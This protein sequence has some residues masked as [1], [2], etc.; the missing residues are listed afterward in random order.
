[1]TQYRLIMV[2]GSSP[3]AGKTTA[4][5]ALARQL[6]RRA[7][8]CRRLSEGELLRMEEFAQF[9][10]AVGC[11]DP[12]AIDA[13]LAAARTL[14]S[15]AGGSEAT[16]ITDALLPGFFWLC[17]RYPP[18]RVAAFSTDLAHV[19]VPLQPLIIYLD[20]DVATAIAR[21]TLA[22]G[23]HWPGPTHILPTNQAT[24]DDVEGRPPAG[25]GG[26]DGIIVRRS[27]TL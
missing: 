19:L 16:W 14:A 20:A 9:D 7:S 21:A 2:S 22:R 24:M 1:M 25:N 10:Q 18:E 4:S 11:N 8:P 23:A 6:T 13:L 17:G 12:D 27:A 5:E 3:G 26:S 15:D